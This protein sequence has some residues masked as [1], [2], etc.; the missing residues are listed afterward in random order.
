MLGASG[1]NRRRAKPLA[2]GAAA[3]SRCSAMIAAPY[4]SAFLFF[5]GFSVAYLGFDLQI[6]R[7][8]FRLWP[9]HPILESIAIDPA[10]S[11]FAILLLRSQKLRSFYENTVL[12]LLIL[13][14]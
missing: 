14:I 10:A 6:Y 3:A 12:A 7:V 9:S 5:D 4:G 13:C 1:L 11:A 8:P 2:D